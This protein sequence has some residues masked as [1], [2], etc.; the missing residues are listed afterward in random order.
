LRTGAEVLTWPG[1]VAWR[2]STDCGAPP[3]A[4]SQSAA[5]KQAP[6]VIRR[7]YAVPVGFGFCWGVAGMAIFVSYSCD[8][9]S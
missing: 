6:I 9:C 8:I 5:T 1:D 4:A 2:P 7:R 3:H